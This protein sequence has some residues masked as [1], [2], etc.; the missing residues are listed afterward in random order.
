[1]RAV[2]VSILLVG[3]A[4]DTSSEAFY[5][6]AKAHSTWHL[7]FDPPAAG[8]PAF[9]TR[10]WQFPADAGD[11]QIGCTCSF[12]LTEADEGDES[13]SGGELVVQFDYGEDCF[14]GQLTCYEDDVSRERTIPCAW[15]VGTCAYSAT[16]TV[17]L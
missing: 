11:C 2:I 17:D 7:Q 10:E 3:C 13:L 4:E 5:D 16:V 15:S 14:G 12:R 9:S 1:M 6:A 8:C